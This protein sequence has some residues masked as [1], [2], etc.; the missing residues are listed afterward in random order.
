MSY[1]CFYLPL[2]LLYIMCISYESQN[3]SHGVKQSCE[4]S[5]R[6]SYL[7]AYTNLTLDLRMAFPYEYF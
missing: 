7:H 6:P 1:S 5:P 3:Y 2:Q 4:L